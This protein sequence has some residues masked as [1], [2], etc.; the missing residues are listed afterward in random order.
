MVVLTFFLLA[1]L[2]STESEVITVGDY[3]PN[4]GGRPMTKSTYYGGR[5]GRLFD[6]VVDYDLGVVPIVGVQSISISY[7]DKVDS[8]QVTYVRSRQPLVGRNLFRAPTHGILKSKPTRIT[9][10]QYEHVVKVEGQTDGKYITQLTIT[11]DGWKNGNTVY[12]PFGKNGTQS[13]LFEG[14]IVAFYGGH[15][16]MHLNSIGVYSIK[17]LKKSDM[18][19]GTGGNSFDDNGEILQPPA[20]Q[21]VGISQIKIWSG[22]VVEAIQVTYAMLGF[23]NFIANQQGVQNNGSLTTIDFQD[24]EILVGIKGLVKDDYI[25]QLTFITL[26]PDGSEGRHGPF[27]K[28]GNCPFSFF[29]NIIAIY[30]TSGSQINKIGIYYII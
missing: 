7:R 15:G 16:L 6:D 24:R 4:H 26:K 11:T 20:P 23:D 8:I 1:G 13:F 29:A 3:I 5:G 27:G 17:E 30:G 12:G 21:F 2:H 18:F 25:S 28:T 10:D 9:L 19:G 14:F 22:D